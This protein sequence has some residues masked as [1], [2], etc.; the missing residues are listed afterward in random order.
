MY[1]MS[2]IKPHGGPTGKITKVSRFDP[3]GTINVSTKCHV[4]PSNR[5]FS[6]D[7]SV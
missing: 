4:N 3:L 7:Q 1:Q 5:Y 6:L 2:W